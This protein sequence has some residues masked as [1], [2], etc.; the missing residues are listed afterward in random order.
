MIELIKGLPDNVVGIVAMGRVTSRECSKV[1]A[2][3]TQAVLKRHGKV[4]LY[5]EVASRFPGAG[6]DALS[7]GD[8]DDVPWERI[9][10]VTD[11]AWVRH[12]VNVLRFLIPAEI[13]VFTTV[14]AA[15]GKSWISAWPEV[16]AAA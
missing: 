9:A 15:E 12:C 14:Q 7:L 1:V 16:D 2:P 4:R 10:I 3:A 13:R 5:Y 8:G 6:W 11:V